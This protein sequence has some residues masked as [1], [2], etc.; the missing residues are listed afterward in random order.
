MEDNGKF[1]R[2]KFFLRFIISF[3][4]FLSTSLGLELVAHL[5][6][7]GY[8]DESALK[9]HQT[10]G[11]VDFFREFYVFWLGFRA[12]RLAPAVQA[13]SSFYVVLCIVLSADRLLQCLGCFWIKLKRIGPKF[14]GDPFESDYSKGPGL[15]YPMVLVQI[16]M[17]NEKE[18]NI[19]KTHCILFL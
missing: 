18:V 17:C 15:N 16:P 11:T 10:S 12:E 4:V 13:L 6:D 5:N 2:G 8:M 3:L 9:K 19:P 7:W 14:E 1:S